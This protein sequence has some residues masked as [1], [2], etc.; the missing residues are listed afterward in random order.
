MKRK[1]SLYIQ[2]LV[3]I[4]FIMLIQ[5]FLVAGVLHLNGTMDALKEKSLENLTQNAKYRGSTVQN[6]MRSSSNIDDF[7]NEARTIVADFC[8]DN[9]ISF[10]TAMN[11][12]IYA[13]ELLTILSKPLLESMRRTGATGSFIFFP[14]RENE[15]TVSGK[16]LYFRDLE[17]GGTSSNYSDVIY[18]KGPA[19]IAEENG[20]L[21]DSLWDKSFN[22]YKEDEALYNSYSS[23]KSGFER[24]PNRSSAELSLWSPPHFANAHTRREKSQCITY[25]RP[26]VIYGELIAIIGSEVQMDYLRSFVPADDFDDSS[27]RGYL[28]GSYDS[29]K[30]DGEIE[31]SI[32]DITG[33]N[34]EGLFE[35]KESITIKRNHFGFYV[36][37]DDN[38][39]KI[40]NGRQPALALPGHRPLPLAKLGFTCHGNGKR[41]FPI[42]QQS[43]QRYCNLHGDFLHIGSFSPGDGG[44]PFN[45]AAGGNCKANRNQFPIRAN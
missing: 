16:G 37:G 38:L 30:G 42:R 23:I 14:R 44:S 22:I 24:Y 6:M 5:T 29:S 45:P 39:Q 11:N 43:F 27:E 31:L 3:P 15:D 17:P 19:S 35:G 25:S 40:P 41:P 21:F 1:G 12:P 26:L 10:E 20:L 18:L 28:L 33:K 32:H 13:N 34:I 7:E 36:Y 2:L 4:I 8:S 9:N